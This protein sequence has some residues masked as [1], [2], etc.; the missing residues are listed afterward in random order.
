[1]KTGMMRNLKKLG[2]LALVVTALSAATIPMASATIYD[3]K[4]GERLASDT[5]YGNGIGVRT[6][7]FEEK[8]NSS[9]VEHVA[10]V[11]DHVEVNA[12]FFGTE[13]AQVVATFTAKEE[14]KRDGEW[15]DI[16]YDVYM[17]RLDGS[18]KT[19]LVKRSQLEEGSVR[20]PD[21]SE[22]T[23]ETL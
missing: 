11:G 13:A 15:T 16:Y 2:A 12:Y 1:M 5:Y 19:H 8:R 21:A 10:A 3:A 9:E 4:S 20:H 14:R 7:D 17:V 23:E 18:D 22:E 6:Y